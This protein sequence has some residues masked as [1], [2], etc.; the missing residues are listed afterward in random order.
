[1]NP[2][3]LEPSYV[4][5]KGVSP[6]CVLWLKVLHLGVYDASHYLKKSNRLTS[7][8]ICEIY[9]PHVRQAVRWLLSDSVHPGSFLW[10]CEVAGYD[11]EHIRKIASME[12]NG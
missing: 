10:I 11:P 4:W 9:L 7:E 3:Q 6:E 12:R 8:D 2:E 5:E 1:M